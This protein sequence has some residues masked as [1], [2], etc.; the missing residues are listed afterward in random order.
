MSPPDPVVA[1]GCPHCGAVD[2]EHLVCPANQEIVEY[3]V[4]SY[5][6]GFDPEKVEENYNMW[7]NEILKWAVESESDGGWYTRDANAE[8]MKKRIQKSVVALAM[9]VK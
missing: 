3:V 9:F 6:K 8:S 7:R 1:Q 5:V 4:K 2:C